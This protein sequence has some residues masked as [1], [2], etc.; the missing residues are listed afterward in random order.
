[1]P[2]SGVE[3]PRTRV[4]LILAGTLAVSDP[5]AGLA[6]VGETAQNGHLYAVGAS[7]PGGV[8]LHEVYADRVVLDRDGSLET[9][10]LPRQLS[11]NAHGL[12]PGL[13]P[14]GNSGEP[15]LADSVQKLIAQGPEV[16]G[17]ILRP[18]PMYANGQLKGFRVYA[19]RDRRK[20]EKLGLK[21]G[22][23]VTQINGVPLSDA[24]RGMEILR[25]LG[26]AG[27]A[28]V[29]VER[30]GATQQLTVDAS[31]VAGMSQPGDAALP[32]P[33]PES[34]AAGPTPE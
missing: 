3:A 5:K 23:L 26:S 29:T 28:Q 6:I 19:G 27:S 17:E 15:A 24:Q 22:D 18:M 7:L 2:A 12:P 20:F 9:L 31:Q 34:P 33:Q 13:S 25:G 32:P 8:K 16:I 14:A 11:A 30:G 21:A 4:A 1:M 10:P